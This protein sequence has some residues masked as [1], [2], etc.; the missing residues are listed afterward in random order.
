QAGAPSSFK[1]VL[2]LALAHGRFVVTREGGTTLPAA[3]PVSQPRYA[4]QPKGVGPFSKLRLVNV[5]PKLGLDFQQG[6][7]RYSMAYDQQAMMGGG[8]CWL[9]YNDDG[10]LDLFAV[11]SYAD[12]DMPEWA[13]HGGLPQS[14]LF[15]NEHGKFVNVNSS[16]HA[17]IRVKGTGCAAADLNG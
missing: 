2:D 13:S 1:R 16:S 6:A 17:G 8:V 15:E 14:A 10:W 4:T 5:A 3:V 9:D 7:F 12:V 11:N